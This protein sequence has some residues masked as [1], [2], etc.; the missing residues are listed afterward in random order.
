[1]R[2]KG[3][4]GIG[5]K[6]CIQS[7]ADGVSIPSRL[8]QNLVQGR[9]FESEDILAEL[10]LFQRSVSS[11]KLFPLG[12]DLS[13]LYSICNRRAGSD[14]AQKEAQ[15]LAYTRYDEQRSSSSHACLIF[16]VLEHAH[17]PLSGSQDFVCHPAIYV[18]WLQNDLR[19]E[20]R[21]VLAIPDNRAVRSPAE[22]EATC[23]ETT[24]SSNPL[25]AW[26]SMFSHTYPSPVSPS[27]TTLYFQP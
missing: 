16:E 15:N 13:L 20:Q 5:G 6:Q 1:M 8:M 2:G 26:V 4:R 19:N 25:V 10:E 23:F 17:P 14:T 9:T 11:T 12:L 7:T 22:D 18:A 3:R 24:V 21:K 27:S